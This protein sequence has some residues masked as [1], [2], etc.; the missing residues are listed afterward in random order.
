[1]PFA[2]STATREDDAA[3]YDFAA[4]VARESAPG[5]IA[6]GTFRYSLPYYRTFF[7][8]AELPFP[9]A[10]QKLRTI[11]DPSRHGGTPCTQLPKDVVD[12][13][14]TVYID[15]IVPQYP[16]FTKEEVCTMFQRFSETGDGVEA[17]TADEQFSIS[18]ILAIATLSSRSRDYRRLVS[19]AEALRGDAFSRLDFGLVSNSPTVANIRHLLLLAIYGSMLPSST[20]LWQIVGDATR[21]AIGIGLHQEAPARSLMSDEV[22]HFRQRLYW[23]VSTEHKQMR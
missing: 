11:N 6:N 1:M 19:M 9:L 10:F 23:T 4:T 16:L 22:T 13:L 3:A 5:G 8:S 17:A 20:N 2:L 12:K 15:R 18:M 21:I 7:L 14:M